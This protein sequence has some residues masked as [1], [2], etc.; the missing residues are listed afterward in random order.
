MDK[1]RPTYISLT[2]KSKSAHQVLHSTRK[3][4]THLQAE[5][6]PYTHAGF[7]IH[8]FCWSTTVKRRANTEM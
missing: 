6:H 5:R 1:H 2:P 8:Y 4:S 7:E 3:Q